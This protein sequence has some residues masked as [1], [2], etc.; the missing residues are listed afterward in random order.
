MRCKTLKDELTENI[1]QTLNAIALIFE[2]VSLKKQDN[3]Q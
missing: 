1:C 2:N 3:K